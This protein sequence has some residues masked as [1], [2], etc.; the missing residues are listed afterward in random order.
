MTIEDKW[1]TGVLHLLTH[2]PAVLHQWADSVVVN[3]AH[4][5]HRFRRKRRKLGS[6]AVIGHL[7]RPLASRDGAADRVKH[8]Y[9]T[10][11]E[12]AHRNS[13]R[14]YLPDLLHRRQPGFVIHSG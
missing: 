5:S 6:T 11:R 14:Q 7:L 10:Q 1:R 12:L 3:A 9:P 13:G 8:Q 2:L 4:R